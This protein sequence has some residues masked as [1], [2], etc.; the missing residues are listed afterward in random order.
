MYSIMNDIFMAV[1]LTAV[2]LFL[3]AMFANATVL[4]LEK[5]G[6]LTKKWLQ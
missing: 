3:I 1:T 6:K 5:L 2:W 4:L